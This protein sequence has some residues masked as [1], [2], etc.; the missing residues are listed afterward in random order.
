MHYSRHQV[1]YEPRARS[2]TILS[3]RTRRK[4][5]A[6]ARRRRSSRTRSATTTRRRPRK[7]GRTGRTRSRP[8]RTRGSAR[9][10]SSI[11]AGNARRR[12]WRRRKQPSC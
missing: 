7:T 5:S 2:R 12:H 11:R 10:T 8:G 4:G 1:G 3:R 6:G 9:W